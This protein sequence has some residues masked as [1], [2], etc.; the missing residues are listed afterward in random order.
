MHRELYESANAL[1]A[2]ATNGQMLCR[3][4]LIGGRNMHEL[5]QLLYEFTAAISGGLLALFA[6]ALFF[7]LTGA[8]WAW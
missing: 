4:C 1:T 3:L 8:E 5:K 6:G 2:V 7:H